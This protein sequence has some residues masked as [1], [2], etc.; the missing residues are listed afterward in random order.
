MTK[1][2]VIL[3]PGHG[4]PDPGC[5]ANGT[6][7]AAVNL[8]I[9]KT[10]KFQ[11]EQEG[12][13]VKLTRTGDE[14]PGGAKATKDQSF[15]YRINPAVLQCTV[16][17]PFAY[18]S[19]HHDIGTARRGGVYYYA[20]WKRALWLAQAIAKATGGW[21]RPDSEVR[22]GRLY[23]CRNAPTDR[24]VLWEVGPTKPHTKAERIALCS[25]ITRILCDIRDR[26]AA[27]S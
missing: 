1:P 10:L 6:T 3:D 4:K 22:F 16:G 20:Q 7:E 5:V 19:I 11:L 17:G 18:I 26:Q 25:P 15:F 8:D 21:C 12:F 13:E 27:E 2:L 14:W 24:A 9:A 23:V